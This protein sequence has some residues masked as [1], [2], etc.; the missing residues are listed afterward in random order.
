MIQLPISFRMA[1][2]CALCL[3]DGGDNFRVFM[4]CIEIVV[5]SLL[6]ALLGELLRAASEAASRG[7]TALP[8]PAA[9]AAALLCTLAATAKA[10]RHVQRLQQLEHLPLVIAPHT[11]RVRALH[12]TQSLVEAAFSL[13]HFVTALARADERELL[14]P[15]GGVGSAAEAADVTSC[16]THAI[17]AL[18]EVFG[19]DHSTTLRLGLSLVLAAHRS[20]SV[21]R[22]VW[23]SRLITERLRASR[24]DAEAA[25]TATAAVAASASN[26]PSVF[27]Q[28][29]VQWVGAID[30]GVCALVCGTPAD[31]SRAEVLQVGPA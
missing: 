30:G 21:H 5:T 15:K 6:P 27:L 28:Q 31:G 19:A 2:L 23:A 29:I 17:D 12:T 26:T 4:D 10:L 13:E 20:P 24:S 16:M 18:A 22:R 7:P 1:S 3:Q 9:P 11:A 14:A 25:A 8:L